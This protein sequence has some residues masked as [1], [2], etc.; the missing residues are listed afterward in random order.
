[1]T[2]SDGI[3]F[4][5][6]EGEDVVRVKELLGGSPCDVSFFIG[7][8][9]GISERET[10]KIIDANIPTVS[11]GKRILRTETASSYV[12]SAISVLWE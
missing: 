3:S 5:C 9:G 10:K 1:M 6:H 4:V 12:L 8:E 2:S 7:P 11:L